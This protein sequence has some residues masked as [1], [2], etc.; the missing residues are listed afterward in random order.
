[1]N[2]PPW[3]DAAHD[4]RSSAWPQLLRQAEPAAA[5]RM[6]RSA[7]LALLQWQCQT[8]AGGA[9]AL[10]ALDEARAREE[11]Q[12]FVDWCVQREFARQWTPTEQGW[13]A[14]SCR[15]LLQNMAAQPELPLPNGGGGAEALR[16]PFSYGLAAL[17]RDAR[18]P[19]WDE[20]QQLDW[21]IRYW[22]QARKSGLA[23]EADF[24]EFWRQ[25]EWTGLQ[26]HLMLLGLACR[27]K[28]GDGQPADAQAQLPMLFAH[29]V[30]VTTRYVELSPLTHLLQQLQGGL[31]QTAFSL[32]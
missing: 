16:G 26:R 9:A 17:L 21:A 1:M 23:V 29:A 25:L 2:A 8:R 20:A 28:H 30:K 15:A 6:M 19:G 32:R 12:G 3:P 18:G 31:T 11:L 22:E 4:P 14:H 7:A 10:P 5:E 13:W 24:G 27:R